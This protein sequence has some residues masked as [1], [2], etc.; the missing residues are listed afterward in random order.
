MTAPTIDTAAILKLQRKII[1]KVY[2][3]V[4]A[5]AMSLCDEGDRVYLNSTNDADILRGLR[6]EWDTYRITGEMFLSSEQEVVA[7]KKRVRELEAQAAAW[8]AD[9]ERLAGLAKAISDQDAKP[10]YNG[11]Y[12]ELRALIAAL[13]ATLAAHDA[14]MKDR[15]HA[16]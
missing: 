15:N 4:A 16:D 1:A 11:R 2:S 10:E 9:A 6:D 13:P 3:R 14:M 8:K 12:S 7:L 5:V